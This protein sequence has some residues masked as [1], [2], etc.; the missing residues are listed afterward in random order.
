[1]YIE[2]IMYSLFLVYRK[3]RKGRTQEGKG[4]AD[5]KAGPAEYPYPT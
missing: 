3:P 5:V 1:V 2:V 4:L